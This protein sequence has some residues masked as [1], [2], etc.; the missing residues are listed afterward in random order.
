MVNG[1]RDIERAA[2][3]SA[4]LRRSAPLPARSQQELRLNPTGLYPESMRA[5][6]SGQLLW[7]DRP[8]RSAFVKSGPVSGGSFDKNHNRSQ[9]GLISA[10]GSAEA[11]PDRK[12]QRHSSKPHE[13]LVLEL[14]A[15]V[16]RRV[17]WGLRTNRYG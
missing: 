9:Q 4:P 16:R 13:S 15:E 17:V 12:A 3:A 7:Y 6:A 2:E 11:G 10:T 5:L 8:T 14:S 1:L